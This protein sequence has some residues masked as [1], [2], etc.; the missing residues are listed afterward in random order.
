MHANPFFRLDYSSSTDT[1]PEAIPVETV[2]G[3]PVDELPPEEIHDETADDETVD[4]EDEPFTR[5]SS[6]TRCRTPFKSVRPTLFS[7]G[8]MNLGLRTL[9]VS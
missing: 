7:V 3:E 1:L 8:E 9:T 4:A 6:R 2:D 5:G